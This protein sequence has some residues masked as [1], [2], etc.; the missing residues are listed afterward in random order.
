MFDPI[1]RTH[2][3]DP[4]RRQD[5]R[6]LYGEPQPGLGNLLRACLKREGFSNLQGFTS[7]PPLLKAL[8]EFEPDLLL[9][10]AGLPGGDAVEL[11]RDIREGRIGR[12][13]FL[14]TIITAWNPSLAFTAAVSDSGCDDLLA[15][16]VSLDQILER[17]SVLVHQRKPFIVT[18]DYIGPE[19]RP[20]DEPGALRVAVPNTLK[21]K[22][23]G[24]PARSP[25]MDDA[26]DGAMRTVNEQRLRSVGE[27][28]LRLVAADIL[29][30][31]RRGRA[32]A[33]TEQAMERL[34]ARADDAQERLAGTPYAPIGNLCA[35]LREVARAIL[36]DHPHPARKD[37]DIL[38]RLAEAIV[39][40]FGDA[41]EAAAVGGEISSSVSHYLDVRGVQAG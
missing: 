25:A 21:A 36:R 32:G 22:I 7:F 19:R 31:Y 20:D 27:S 1:G 37:L 9:I 14:A 23:A 6:I 4:K 28:I 16:P 13:P 17:I 33:T 26:F 3:L 24:Q 38:P 41:R 35:T 2:G 18:S 39:V 10:D 29:P 34:L 30:A 8:T 11:I 12:S 15:K 5:I 40:G